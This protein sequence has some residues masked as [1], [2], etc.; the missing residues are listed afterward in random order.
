MVASPLSGTARAARARSR[1]ARAAWELTQIARTESAWEGALNTAF[2]VRDLAKGSESDYTAQD[3]RLSAY[4]PDISRGLVMGWRPPYRKVP[5]MSDGS[6]PRI[7]RHH[8]AEC[9]VS[10]TIQVVAMVIALDLG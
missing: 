10:T 2:R 4:T 7:V 6:H 3:F 9:G 8:R 5:W 1:F